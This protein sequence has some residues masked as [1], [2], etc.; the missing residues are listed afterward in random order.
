MS[1]AAELARA[2]GGHRSGDGYLM[3][4][5]VPGHGRGKGDRNPSLLVKDGHS[6]LLVKCFA[7]CAADNILGALG[8]RGLDRHHIP[9]PAKAATASEA[10]LRLRARHIWQDAVAI[11]GTPAEA[12]LRQ[13]RGLIPRT[14]P[15]L[16]FT[17]HFGMPALVAAVQLSDDKLS[18]VQITYLDPS[19]R[20]AAVAPVRRTVGVLGDG[21][22]RLGAAGERLG[23]AEGVEDALA[24]TQLSGAPCWACLGAG[25]MYRVAVPYAVREIHVFADDDEPGRVAA[26]RTADHHRQLG[27]R[28][29]LRLPPTGFK[30]WGD[31][32]MP[33]PR[34]AA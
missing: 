9:V 27:R 34:E 14:S 22:V 4:C 7:G 30:D 2:F 6:R 33:C 23:L 25:R 13:H 10:E 12:Y 21:A 17:M 3:R 31:V 32:V 28:V 19:G 5:P 18:A 24:A 26:E 8:D 16:R 11:A 1:A 29:V 15:A 20:K